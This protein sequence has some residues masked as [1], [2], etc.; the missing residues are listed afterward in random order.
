MAFDVAVVIPTLISHSL[1]RAVRSVFKQDFK[2]KIQIMVGLDYP[3]GNKEQLWALQLQC[4]KNVQMDVL[5]LGYST[6]ANSTGLYYGY[7]GGA[8]RT[9]LTFAANARY[10]AYLDDDNYYEPYHISSLMDLIQSRNYDW[11]ISDRY[12]IHAKTGKRLPDEIIPWENE[13]MIDTNCILIDKIK[14]H[15]AIHGWAVTETSLGKGYYQTEDGMVYG[16]NVH[17][18][19]TLRRNRIIH[20][21]STGLKSVAYQINLDR[22]LPKKL[23][24]ARQAIMDEFEKD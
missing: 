8:L 14:C 7:G 21:A 2:G 16:D 15:E 4:P 12:P 9:I 18:T 5:H 10:V 6:R 22:P 17:F 3:C 1:E 20:M 24:S 11:V 19:K 23:K 13:K